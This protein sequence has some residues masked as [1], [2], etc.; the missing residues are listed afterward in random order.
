VQC[1]IVKKL[2]VQ[3]LLQD[4]RRWTRIERVAAILIVMA[5]LVALPA[6]LVFDFRLTTPAHETTGV[7]IAF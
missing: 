4:W 7:R 3:D 5:L 6:A 2:T 1:N